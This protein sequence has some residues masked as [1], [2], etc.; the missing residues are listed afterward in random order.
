MRQRVLVCV[1]LACMVTATTAS[2]QGLPNIVKRAGIGGSVGGIFPFDDEVTLFPGSANVVVLVA[3][4]VLPLA[5]PFVKRQLTS[6]KV[7]CGRVNP[8]MVEI[9]ERD[10]F[11]S[12]NC[13]IFALLLFEIR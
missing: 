8:L 6:P 1:V 10:R 3:K 9:C 13:I 4:F 12:C 11:E 7:H 2:A 5:L